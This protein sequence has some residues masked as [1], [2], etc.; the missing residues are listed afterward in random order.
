MMLLD[1]MVD[2]NN[3]PVILQNSGEVKTYAFI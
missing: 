3:T 1:V 2:Q